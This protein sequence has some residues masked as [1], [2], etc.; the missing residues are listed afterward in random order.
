MKY[1]GR[2]G[3]V[4]F[5]LGFTVATGVERNPIQV[6]Y[7]LV[8]MGAACVCFNVYDKYTKRAQQESDSTQPESSDIK[9]AA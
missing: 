1:L 8:L 9:E 2:I 6:L 7:A 5:T 4:L 3:G